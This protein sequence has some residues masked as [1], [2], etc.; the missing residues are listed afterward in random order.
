MEIITK[1]QNAT[2][3]WFETRG[4]KRKTSENG[5]RPEKS[6]IVFNGNPLGSGRK[7]SGKALLLQRISIIGF[8]CVAGNL[9][10]V[11]ILYPI[12]SKQTNQDRVALNKPQYL[13]L[14]I[15]TPLVSEVELCKTVLSAQVLN[16]P[17]PNVI[18]WG[19][20]TDGKPIARKDYALDRVAH[21]YRHLHDLP[22]SVDDGMVILLDGP[23]TWFQLRPEVLLQRYYTIIRQANKRLAK[24]YGGSVT[25]RVVFATQTECNPEFQDPA[26]ESVPEC[27]QHKAPRKRCVGPGAIVGPARDVRAVMKQVRLR[28]EKDPAANVVAVLSAIYEEQE[29]QR[30]TSRSS[31]SWSKWQLSENLETDAEPSETPAKEVTRKKGPKMWADTMAEMAEQK[32]GAVKRSEPKPAAPPHQ[33]LGIGLDYN[34]KLGAAMILDPEQVTWTTIANIPSDIRASAPPFW[35]VSG[36]EP[37]LP[38]AARWSDVELL[39]VMDSDTIPAMLYRPGAVPNSADTTLSEDLWPRLWLSRAARSLYT[40]AQFLPGTVVAHVTNEHGREQLFWNRQVTMMKA[41]VKD[42]WGTFVHWEEM[43]GSSPIS[44]QVFQDNMGPWQRREWH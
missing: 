36:A 18:G 30:E 14:I 43:C 15:P 19:N 8:L 24:R 25:Q 7:L 16:Y 1:L 41:G 21:I 20:G 34:N 44:S 27:A 2:G 31:S 35:T 6:S 42:Q 37:D 10:L 26:C 13:S 17:I 23:D 38:Q 12:F 5:T 9:L 40:A 3:S 33:D 11:F 22:T 32:K 29:F 39:G 4:R 28:L